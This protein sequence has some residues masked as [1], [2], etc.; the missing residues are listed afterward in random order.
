[1]ST[2]YQPQTTAVRGHCWGVVLEGMG[3]VERC[4]LC[5]TLKNSQTLNT[6]CSGKRREKEAAEDGKGA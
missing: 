5:N 4:V 6:E 3:W 1:M 2:R